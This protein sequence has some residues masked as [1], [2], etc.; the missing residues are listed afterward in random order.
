MCICSHLIER[1]AARLAAQRSG[2]SIAGKSQ[3][4]STAAKP[5]WLCSAEAQWTQGLSAA[6]VEAGRC[7]PFCCTHVRVGKCFFKRAADFTS[8][9]A[10]SCDRRVNPLHL[11]LYPNTCDKDVSHFL[12]GTRGTMYEGDF[13]PRFSQLGGLKLFH[14]PG[15]LGRMM[16]YAAHRLGVRMCV[17]DPLGAKS[18]A[19]Q[20]RASTELANSYAAPANELWGYTAKTPAFHLVV[21]I[22]AFT[23]GLG[24]GGRVIREGQFSGTDAT[25]SC[26]LFNQAATVIDSIPPSNL[27]GNKSVTVAACFQP[28]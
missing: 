7:E 15:Q 21:V 20:A 4:Y 23:V 22:A 27:G 2:S 6:W 25:C 19:G 26:F 12:G 10:E 5:V 16:V 28:G 18:P 24:P 13:T 14:W 3:P 11:C 1:F 9:F 17:L 8:H